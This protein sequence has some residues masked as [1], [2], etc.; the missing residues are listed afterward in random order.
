MDI[1]GP[2]SEI[3]VMQGGLEAGRRAAQQPAGFLAFGPECHADL[4]ALQGDDALQRPHRLD[5][6][7]EADTPER[8]RDALRLAARRIL[9][10]LDW[11]DRGAVLEGQRNF[12]EPAL[13]LRLCRVRTRDL[14]RQRGELRQ[15]DPVECRVGLGEQR[16]CDA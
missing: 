13:R 8:R 5:V 10:D 16:G 7:R 3:G 9:L 12:R 2:G 14:E 15:L 6:E 4:T 11:Q 1:D